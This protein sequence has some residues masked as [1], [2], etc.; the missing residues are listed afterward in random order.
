MFTTTTRPVQVEVTKSLG[1]LKIGQVLNASIVTRF[2]QQRVEFNTRDIPACTKIP[3]L[4]FLDNGKPIGKDW[5]SF[6]IVQ[7]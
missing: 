3:H 4:F 1:G 5:E 2:G 7:G 6:R